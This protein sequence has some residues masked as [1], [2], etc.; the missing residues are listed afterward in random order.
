MRVVSHFAGQPV[1]FDVDVLEADT[2][3]LA[4]T[5]S[6]PVR[7]KVSYDVHEIADG[8]SRIEARL[9]LSRRPGLLGRVLDQAGRTMLRAGVLDRTVRKIALAAAAA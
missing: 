2:R 3:R 4:L 9:E 7:L 1:G 6:G 8:G 5:A